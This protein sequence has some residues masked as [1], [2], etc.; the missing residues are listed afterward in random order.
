MDHPALVETY[1]VPEAAKALGVSELTLKRWIEDDLVPEPI[2]KDTT[3]SYR[4]Y[5][6]GELRVIARVL[7]AHQREFSYY[8]AKHEQTRHQM[9]QQM[10]GY[11]ASRI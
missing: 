6:I 11:R 5:S 7:R 3:R 8:T 2:L 1:T 10:Q 9:M 4:H